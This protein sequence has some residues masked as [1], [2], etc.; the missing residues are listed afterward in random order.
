M[1]IYAVL[2]VCLCLWI[3]Y[4]PSTCRGQKT[5][6]ISWDWSYR[7][8]SSAMWLLVIKIRSS[9][10]ATCVFNCWGISPAPS[11]REFLV[12]LSEIWG[13]WSVHKYGETIGEVLF[14]DSHLHAPLPACPFVDDDCPPLAPVLE[15]HTE[16]TL[17]WA[18]VAGSCQ[19]LEPPGSSA[20]LLQPW[21]C[22]ITLLALQS[23]SMASLLEPFRTKKELQLSK[24][25]RATSA[26]HLRKERPSQCR[27]GCAT[28]LG[29]SLGFVHISLL[30]VRVASK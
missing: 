2:S 21:V 20:V 10:R 9:A 22:L 4:V 25:C 16:K 14:C 28:P 8:L 1:C 13:V 5:T 26:P 12:P 19:T 23:R 27:G 30:L 18:W 15:N 17:G 6:W 29:A 24:T 3:T 7:W 11:P